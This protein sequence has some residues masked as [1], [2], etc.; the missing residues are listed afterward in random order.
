MTNDKFPKESEYR[1]VLCVCAMVITVC[2]VFA[3]IQLHGIKQAQQ[4]Q[5]CVDYVYDNW[6]ACS[7]VWD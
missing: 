2:C 4:R 6:P 1:F 7:R 3:V 5:A